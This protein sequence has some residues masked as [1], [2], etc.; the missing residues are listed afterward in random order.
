M[1]KVTYNHTVCVKC[2]T[3][4]Q[5]S[6]IEDALNGFTMQQTDFPFVCII[7]DDAST[8]GEQAVIKH[9]LADHFNLE[10][11]AVVRNEETDDYKLTYA[12]HKTNHNCFFVVILLKYNHYKKKDK[13]PY[14]REWTDSVKYVAIC[15]G[16]DYWTDPLKLQKQVEFLETH[17]DFSICF[18]PVKLLYQKDRLLK[19]DNL[20]DGPS[21]TT[22]YDLAKGNYIHTLSVL[23]RNNPLVPAEVKQ[24]GRVATG[25]YVLHM[26]N[27]KY[28][29]IKRLPDCMGVYR[30][31]EGSVWGLKK[32][33][34]RYPLWNEMLI[35]LMP[36]FDEDIQACL[37]Q[38]YLDNCTKMYLCGKQKV[39]SSYAYRLG[40]CILKPIFWIKSMVIK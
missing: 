35:K 24:V 12:Q 1:L 7:V 23:F 10:D 30:L 29:R 6:F 36:L 33:M 11:D 25:D 17:L 2:M 19:D 5:A 18:H 34:E 27:A 38:Q 26:I 9:Y 22:I 16:D 31:N 8:D 40:K 21:E 28:G 13:E 32:D 4:N 20:D 15:E 39:Y 3:Y 14:F 37:H